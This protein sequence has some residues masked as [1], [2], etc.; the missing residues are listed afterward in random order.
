MAFVRPLLY[1]AL[2]LLMVVSIIELSFISSM[3]GWLH[4]NA[5]GT[6]SFEYRG[7]RHNL[8]GEPANLIVDQGHTSNGAAGTAF[9]L[10]GCGGILAL[11]LRNR[12]NPGKFSR[13]FY[14]T[15]LVFNVLS[16]LLILTAL[17]YTFVVT[18]NHNGQRIDPGVAAGLADDEKYPLQSW[19]PQN[20]FSAFLKLDLT[21]SNERND[22]EHHLRLMRGWQYN[23]IPFF[24][25]H[26]AETGLA[27]WDAMLRRK[28][29]VPA[30]APPKHTV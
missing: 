10:I 21:N 9:V 24:I 29:P 15:W 4:G 6:F 13:F 17:I 26:L 3:V 1:V 27:L 25:I 2:G 7:T 8:K 16:L 30:Y 5:S 12:P 18:N 11:I 23:L 19:T 28:E 22:I 14:N 20:W